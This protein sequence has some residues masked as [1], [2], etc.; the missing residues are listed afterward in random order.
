LGA[1]LELGPE[2]AASEGLSLGHRNGD[3][4]GVLDGSFA[5]ALG[6]E[7]EL[8]P[9]SGIVDEESFGDP[10]GVTIEGVRLSCAFGTEIG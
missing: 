7:L 10:L 2:S 8:G 9:E 4:L 3:W 1:E 5:A 6:A